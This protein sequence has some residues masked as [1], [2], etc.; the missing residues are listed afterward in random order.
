[1]MDRNAGLKGLG[2]LYDRVNVHLQVE[3][4]LLNAWMEEDKANGINEQAN[5]ETDQEA[6]QDYKQQ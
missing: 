3:K 1:M 5:D 4:Q 6:K 2:H